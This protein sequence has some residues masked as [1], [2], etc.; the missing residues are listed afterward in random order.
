M[1]KPA[2]GRIRSTGKTN[3]WPGGATGEK[4]SGVSLL[5]TRV[6]VWRV[7]LRATRLPLGEE[8]PACQDRGGV[9]AR[10]VQDDTEVVP[11][12]VFCGAGV[13]EV[14]GV[15]LDTTKPARERI[16]FKG[17]TNVWPGGVTGV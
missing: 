15:A 2:R 12:G 7:V 8:G 17:K 5:V 13:G 11:P 10:A 4:G 14:A 1:T 16:R 3:V 6:R 9:F